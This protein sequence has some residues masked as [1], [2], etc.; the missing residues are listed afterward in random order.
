MLV[1]M[2]LTLFQAI[3]AQEE[4]FQHSNC[5]GQ[6]GDVGYGGDEFVCL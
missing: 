2:A 6:P 4:V 3:A 1:E 5:H